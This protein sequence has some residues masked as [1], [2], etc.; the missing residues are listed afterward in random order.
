MHETHIAIGHGGRTRMM[1]DPKSQKD[2]VVRPSLNNGINL[3]CQVDL[4]DLQANL[5]NMSKFILVYQDQLRKLHTIFWIFSPLL[6]HL[7]SSILII[8]ES[9]VTKLYKFVENRGTTSLRDLSNVQ[10]RTLEICYQRGW[11]LIEIQ[12]GL[13]ARVSSAVPRELVNNIDTEEGLEKTNIK[14]WRWWHD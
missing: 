1:M 9:C 4:L 10:T 13:T 6:A 8:V 7:I 11:K 5:D 3:R 14:R 12:N 2:V